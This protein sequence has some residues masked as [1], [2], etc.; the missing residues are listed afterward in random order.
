MGTRWSEEEK[1]I[2]RD[3]WKSP[4]PANLQAHRLPLRNIDNINRMAVRLKLGAKRRDYSPM[5]QVIRELMRDG[6]PRTTKEIAARVNGSVCQVRILLDA[7]VTG[8][9]FH[10]MRWSQGG[11]NGQWQKVYRFGKGRNAEC[12]APM[13][14]SERNRKF[15]ERADPDEMEFRHKRYYLR[16][17]IKTG[18]ATRRDPL[19]EALFGRAA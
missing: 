8:K 9:R 5:L 3:I 11:R 7:E 18:R 1:A 16:R 15:L 13:T 6:E 2:L 10:V 4:I 17:L 19:T 14:Q 12:P